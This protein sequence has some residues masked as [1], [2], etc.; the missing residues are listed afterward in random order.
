MDVL[1][2]ALRLS[3][4]C[5]QTEGRVKT[6]ASGLQVPK[7]LALES[8]T[9]YRSSREAYLIITSSAGNR[10]RSSLVGIKS[11]SNTLA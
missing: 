8:T 10:C 7:L 6:L 9:L 3:L 5:H 2:L 4:R 1:C 11:H